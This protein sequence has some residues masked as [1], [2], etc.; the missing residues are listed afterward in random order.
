[1]QKLNIIGS[2]FGSSGYDSHTRQL[3]NALFDEGV[4][5]RIQTPMPVDWVRWVSDNELKMIKKK[6]DE[7]RTSIFVGLPSTIPLITAENPK[8]LYSYIIRE[9]EVCPLYWLKHL[10]NLRSDTQI[11]GIL[12]PSHHTYT[13]ILNTIEKARKT[14]FMKELYNLDKIKDKIHIIP[15]GVNT[16]LFKPKPEKQEK[17]FT[18]ISNKG[19]SSGLEDRGGIQYALK[20]FY[21]EF[22]VEEKVQIIAKINPVYNQPNW[23][24]NNEMA[25]LGITDKCNIKINADNIMFDKLPDLYNKGHCFVSAT[26]GDAFNLPC[27]EAMACGLPVIT[28]AYGGQI[29]YC[30]N[31]N[32]W[33]VDYKLNDVTWDIQYEGSK[34][35]TP[36]ILDLRKK[37][38][39]TFENQNEVK[40][41]G[42]QALKDIQKWTWE[43]SA[44]KL[45]KLLNVSLKRE[46]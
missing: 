45:L 40:K 7:N 42:E 41:K 28:T 37:M 20:A 4:D 12:V 6:P 26:R 13:S 29:D 36:N 39:Y 10:S 21:K 3:S 27:A 44:K 25:N 9:G 17:I 30:N 19:W 11:T 2:I 46:L 35:A 38:R 8:K 16:K 31:D 43:N 14:G 23:N 18:F 33:L 24:L 34:W 5:V 22:D 32:S 15:H 1:M